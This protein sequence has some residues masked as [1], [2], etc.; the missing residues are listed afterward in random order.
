M[1]T[2]VRFLNSAERHWKNHAAMNKHNVSSICLTK[3][4]CKYHGYLMMTTTMINNISVYRSTSVL[5]LEQV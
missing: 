1:I 3:Y 2:T 5:N 4:E